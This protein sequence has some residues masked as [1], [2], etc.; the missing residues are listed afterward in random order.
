MPINYYDPSGT[1]MVDTSEPDTWTNYTLD[2]IA[3]IKSKTS[4]P[5]AEEEE[6]IRNFEAY[7]Q[8]EADAHGMEYQEMEDAILWSIISGEPWQ[9][10]NTQFEDLATVYKSNYISCCVTNGDYFSNKMVPGVTLGNIA[11]NN[12]ISD[13]ESDVTIYNRRPKDKFIAMRCSFVFDAVDTAIAIFASLTPDIGAAIST[14]IYYG[15][16]ATK[17]ILIG[18]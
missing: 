14:V 16:Q 2:Q 7:V 12:L 18:Y 3:F 6:I 11:T 13:W 9:Y 4:N 17:R 15:K 8:S 10:Y 1:L 5:Y